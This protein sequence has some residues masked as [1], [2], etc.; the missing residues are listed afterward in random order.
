MDS[1]A[2][3]R[4][5]HDGGVGWRS[6]R[7]SFRTVEVLSRYIKVSCD[8]AWGLLAWEVMSESRTQQARELVVQDWG[9]AFWA[10]ETTG[11]WCGVETEAGREAEAH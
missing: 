9:R 6:V 8:L 2:A 3:T 7:E 1:D 11:L 4:G 5:L 10:Q